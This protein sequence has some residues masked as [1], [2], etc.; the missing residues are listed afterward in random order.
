MAARNLRSLEKIITI[1]ADAAVCRAI[2]RRCVK[3]TRLSKIAHW[4]SNQL[5]RS[6]FANYR[7]GR[8]D[9]TRNK[10][11]NWYPGSLE[12]SANRLS[13]TLS[14]TNVSSRRVRPSLRVS[15]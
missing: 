7:V 6:T 14:T 15:R 2:D 13:S 4:Q 12:D 11:I 9:E 3:T 5:E 8:R 10:D 1:G